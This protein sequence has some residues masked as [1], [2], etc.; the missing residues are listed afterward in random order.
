MLFANRAARELLGIGPDD[1]LPRVEMHDFFDTTPE[2][3]AEMRQ[4]IIEYGRWSGELDVRGVD[5]RLPASVVVTGHRD[6]SGRYEYFSAL[7]TRH[8]R[9]TR[10][11]RGPPAQRGGAAGDRAVVAAPDLRGRRRRHRPRVEPRVR[12]AVRLDGG[13]GDRI[14]SA[15]RRLRR[16]DRRRSPRRVFAGDTVRTREARYAR[17]D[18]EPVDVNVVG[19]AA[20]QREGPRRLGGGRRRRRERSEAGRARAPRERGAVP[21]ARAELHRH[22][23]DHRRRR[24]RRLPQPEHAAVPR[25]RPG[26][27]RRGSR[28]LRAVRGGPARAGRAVR[29]AAADAGCD[30]DDPSTASSA[31]TASCAWIE[32]VATNHLDDPA[33][34]GIVTNARDVTD[35]VEAEQTI[36][37]SEERLQRARR[38]HLRRH[39]RH[40]APTGSSSTRARRASRC[41]ATRPATWPEG[42]SVFDTVHPDDRPRIVE[43]WRAS[44]STPGPFRPIEI[45][46]QK[47]DGSWMYAE[48]V[49]NNLLDD[50]AGQRH[51]RHLARRHRAQARRGGAARERGPAARERGAL[52]RRGRR[53][54][55]ARVPVPARHDADL[56]QPRVRRVL[57]LR[58]A[59]R[60]PASSS[61]TCGPRPSARSC[62]SGCSPFSAADSVRTHVERE[63][64]L[65]GSLRWYQWTDRAFLDEDGAVVEYQSVGHDVTEQRRAAEFTGYQA[66][67]LEQVARGVPLDETPA[68]HRGRARGPLPAFLVRHHAARRRVVDAARRRRARACPPRFLDALDGTPLGLAAASCGAAAHLREPVFVSD[69]ASD[70]PFGRA[71][72]RSRSS[73]DIHASW[74]IPIIAS[75]G[76]DGARHA[77]RVRRRAAPA[78]RRA[79]PDLPPARAARV[80][81]D[82]AQ[83]VRGAARAPVDARPAHRPAEPAAVHRPARPG[84]RALPAHEVDRRRRVPRPRPVQERQRQPGPRRRRRAA[85]GGRAHARGA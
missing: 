71:P 81:R 31:S 16:G 60:W 17:R 42:K 82:R 25:D 66:E 55:R 65:D 5:L 51:R 67:I 10:A 85:R 4:S 21:V 30:G 13:R 54:D 14:A 74:S 26:V 7:V 28:R 63:V 2:L 33:V 3:L 59:T 70:E 22:G 80:D 20:A 37:A 57:R 6:A 29:A 19:R 69:I 44:V 50:P 79:P 11:R 1:P 56:R 34:R 52:P 68:H 77:R 32:M 38:E 84:D 58:P 75:D 53:P 83:G 39:L 64:S 35:R 12:G 41:T 72:R 18:G 45:R 15:L 43:L 48:I 23:H 9:A 40:R 36:R 49:A 61:S 47:A 62:S 27:R 73:T 8:H 76:G 24:P 78:R 46:L